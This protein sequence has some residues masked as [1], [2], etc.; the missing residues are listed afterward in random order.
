MDPRSD[1]RS[2]M[3]ATGVIWLMVATI[4]FFV[5]PALALY[6][7][8]EVLFGVLVAA[9]FSM[10]FVWN[11]GRPGTAAARAAGQQQMQGDAEKRKRQ[12]R[13]DALLDLLDEDTLEALRQRL[14]QQDGSSYDDYSV[15]D[16]GELR[17][18]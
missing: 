11:W 16:D 18:R 13:A 12:S 9:L 17:R 6:H 8:E 7:S 3:I 14:T 15:T 2:R 10:G 1:S 5:G 4:F